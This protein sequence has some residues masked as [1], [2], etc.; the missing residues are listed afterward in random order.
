MV[1]SI[2]QIIL[3]ISNWVDFDATELLL[4]NKE[5]VNAGER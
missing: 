2:S 5:N 4:E 1:F 3:P